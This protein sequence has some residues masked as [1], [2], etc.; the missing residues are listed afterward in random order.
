MDDLVQVGLLG[1]MRAADRY[2]P[3][4]ETRFSTY[5]AWW[6][7]QSI[8]RTIDD[9]GRTIRLPVHVHER[10]RKFRRARRAIETDGASR[11]PDISRVADALGWTTTDTAR[12]ANLAETRVV[13][14]DDRMDPRGETTYSERMEADT[15]SP[16]SVYEVF[17]RDERLRR[18]VEGLR[19]RRLQDI[20]AGRFGLDGGDALTLQQLGERYGV[21]R[22]RIRQLEAKALRALRQRAHAGEFLPCQ[23]PDR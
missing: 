22:E 3:A 4:F 19:N 13:S 10:V 9:E 5:A 14:L 21:T 1:L 7:R 2:D 8:S 20:V 23:V 18:L 6:F 16:E 17:E 12:I 11:R 15:P